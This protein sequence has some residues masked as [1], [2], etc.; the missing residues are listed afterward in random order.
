MSGIEPAFMMHLVEGRFGE[1]SRADLAAVFQAHRDGPHRTMLIHFHGGLVSKEAGIAGAVDLHERYSGVA[2]C[3]FPIWETGF[4]EVLQRGWMEIA[5]DTLFQVIRDRAMSAVFA[6]A[7]ELVDSRGVTLEYQPGSFMP[8]DLEE[9]VRGDGDV[10]L[11]LQNVDL[12]QLEQLTPLQERQLASAFARDSRLTAEFQAAINA[13]VENAEPDT[14]AAFSAP[15]IA[16]R[17]SVIDPQVLD[18]LLAENDDARGIPMGVA[19][20]ILGIVKDVIWRFI[21]RKQHGLHATVTEEILRALYVSA[22]GI[23]VWGEM[24]KYA[25]N[26]FQDGPEWGGTA[27]LDEIQQLPDD[28]QVLLIGHSAGAIFISELLL[29]AAARG[30]QKPLDL[31]FLAPAARSDLFAHALQEAAPLIRN[32]RMYTMTDENE[33]RDVLVRTDAAGNGLAWFYPRSLLYFIAGILE[34][35]VDAPLVGMQRFYNE[36]VWNANDTSVNAVADFVAAQDHRVCWSVA[37]DGQ[38]LRFNANATSHG[39]FGHS[40]MLR[41]EMNSTIDGICEILRTGQF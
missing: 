28:K 35:E 41:G 39:D 6:K 15:N 9:S 21:R 32:F 12:S 26:A 8:M 13:H 11:P 20:R 30:M 1:T 22:A 19:L 17:A 25:H 36:S 34:R 29:A 27:L 33:C 14:R 4:F 31:I 38:D 40:K 3:L 23:S 16:P 24:K 37:Q 18:D 2:S 7:K 5:R 10:A